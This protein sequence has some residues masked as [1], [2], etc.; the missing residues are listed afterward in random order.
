M[1][2]LPLVKLRAIRLRS[3]EKITLAGVPGHKKA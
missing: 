2:A 3:S 1:Q